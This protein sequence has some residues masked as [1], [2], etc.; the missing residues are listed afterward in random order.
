MELKFLPVWVRKERGTVG[1]G[2]RG[3]VGG[4]TAL[5][6][7]AAFCIAAVGFSEEVVGG[8]HLGFGGHF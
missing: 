4:L 5:A 6:Q 7:L 3:G 8:F 1:S 2:V